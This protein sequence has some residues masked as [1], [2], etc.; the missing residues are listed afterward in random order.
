MPIFQLSALK[1][2]VLS[3]IVGLSSSVLLVYSHNSPGREIISTRENHSNS[4]VRSLNTKE[5]EI[6]LRSQAPQIALIS[7]YD[8]SQ[9]SSQIPVALTISEGKNEINSAQ[10]AREKV[11]VNPSPIL[12]VSTEDKMQ[13]YHELLGAIWNILRSTLWVNEKFGSAWISHVRASVP[14]DSGVE[15]QTR[16]I[17]ISV[18]D[19]SNM[20]K[21]IAGDAVKSKREE[22]ASLFSDFCYSDNFKQP[23]LTEIKNPTEK[24]NSSKIKCELK[25]T[26]SNADSSGSSVTTLSFVRAA[27]NQTYSLDIDFNT[28][29]GKNSLMIQ[30]VSYKDR[31]WY[32]SGIYQANGAYNNTRRHIGGELEKSEAAGFP[33]TVIDREFSQMFQDISANSTAFYKLINTISDCLIDRECAA[34][35]HREKGD[36]WELS[37][38]TPGISRQESFYEENYKHIHPFSRR[39]WMVA[40]KVQKNPTVYSQF[41]KF[42][43][44]DLEKSRWF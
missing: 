7:S 30:Y 2:A 28:E 41:L 33:I 37:Q 10:F 19:I 12:E 18:E 40:E 5:S 6:E 27:E 9:E 13:A 38:R 34:I 43:L 11:N 23:G 16:E 17:K 31:T 42:K 3:A 14:K 39:Y 1:Y 21:G 44:S 15:T 8:N 26:V 35:F 25:G 29:G 36:V 22:M 4:A 32:S 20:K 24:Y